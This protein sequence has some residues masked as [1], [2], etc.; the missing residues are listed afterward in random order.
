MSE[1]SDQGDL[2]DAAVRDSIQKALTTWDPDAAALRCKEAAELRDQ[3]LGRFPI[4]HWLDM[5]IED[6]ALGVET[7][8]GSFCWWME[9]KTQAIG[10]IRGGTARKHLIWRRPDG[11][12]RWPK[13][14]PTPQDAWNAV[15]D[16]FVGM[17][18]LAGEGHFDEAGE[19]PALAGAA[20]L[21][22]KTLFMYFPDDLIPVSAKPHIDHF[23]RALGDPAANWSTV[24]ANRRLLKLLRAQ[25][26]LEGMSSQELGYFLYHW[27]DPRTTVQVVKIA[28]GEKGRFW[29]DC[30]AG[31]Y[32]CVGWDLVGDLSEF[33]DK[34]SYRNA[35]RSAYAYD[36]NESQVTLKSN[37]LWTLTELR[38]GDQVVANRGIS[39]V[40][41]IGTVTDLGY[42]WLPARDEYRH[43]VS[44][45]WDVS[46][47]RN[48]E[49]IK[50]WGTTT[51]RKVTAAQL[52]A[53]TGESD[54]SKPLSVDAV[55]TEIEQD[56]ARRGQVIL[57]GPPGT[58][59]TYTARRAAV[60]LL[61]GGSQKA[62]AAAVL[63]DEQLARRLESSLSVEGAE[64]T[65][66]WFMVANPSEWAWKTLFAKG[67]VNYARGKLHR[68]YPLV[69]AGDLVVGYE[70][71]PTKRVVALARVVTEYEPESEP[72]KALVLE[73]VTPVAN[74][75]SWAE[76]QVDPVLSES[77]PMRFRCQG[78]LFALTAIEADRLLS[79]LAERD[80]SLSSFA[81][82]GSRRLTRVTF[83]PSYTYE[84]FVE[85]Y[86]PRPSSAGT[87]D[88][89]L[90]DG[91]FKQV[92]AAAAADPDHLHIVLI[93][94]INRGNIPKIFG[95]LITLLEKDKRSLTVRLPQSGNAFAVP[96][97]V[98]II[99]TMNTA[100][101]SIHLLDTA[102]RRRFAFI[103]LLPDSSTLAGATVGPLALDVFLDNLNERI[104]S[105]AGVGRERQI[106]H[107]LFYQD[108]KV[109]ESPE[110]FM[111]VFRSELLPLLQ[112][113]L[114]EDYALLAEVLGTKLIDSTLQRPSELASQPDELCVAL[115]E[116]F[117]ATA[118]P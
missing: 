41:A 85:G 38:P 34:E 48:I 44:V 114:Y 21:R 51:V 61:E 53:I 99:A 104:R 69:R 2:S 13:E 39:E 52:K 117:G 97:N 32:I 45:D 57:Y 81:G 105:R 115:A 17:L 118:T 9:Y 103:E 75:L 86:R 10:S 64:S 16:G 60:W 66:V 36:G 37:E 11:S 62:A 42:Q 116:E 82:R 112:E 25:P 47:A 43:T 22:T 100:D 113:Y 74:G 68:N 87:L 67:S 88:L 63:G 110:A 77:E 49:P 109:I 83:H 107:A 59:K 15:R 91:V 40:L 90:T 96:P 8:G 106:G 26:A 28:P 80:P 111:S 19:V 46:T 71:T 3:F 6:Y 89:V 27:T 108:G 35:F 78:T 79:Q 102:L 18:A 58:G 1:M 93:D 73:A 23:L 56:L 29:D 50:A 14:Y 98:A 72:D 4:D 92:C 70:S 101:R 24:G 65:R 7:E 55:Y 54:P 33:E 30:L 95:E 12:W 5:S 76:L 20:A 84:D 94:E 31:G